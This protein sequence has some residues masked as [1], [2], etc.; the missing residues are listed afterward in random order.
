M[1]IEKEM[2]DCLQ[3]MAQLQKKMEHLQQ[4]KNNKA[5][6]E[7]VK[8]Q[9]VE[10]NLKVMSDWL[11]EYGESIEEIERERVIVEQHNKLSDRHNMNR[12]TKEEYELIRERYLSLQQKSDRHYKRRQLLDNSPK[13]YFMKQYIE[14]THNMFII[15]QKRIDELEKKVESYSGQA[16]TR[17]DTIKLK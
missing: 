12:L 2:T 9:E 17:P 5:A 6:Q 10:P 15:Q 11:V 7:V 16:K 14:A 4:E 13:M 3:Q 8:R 1:A